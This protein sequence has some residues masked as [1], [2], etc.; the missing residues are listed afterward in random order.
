MQSHRYL[1]EGISGH[2][3]PKVMFCSRFW[4]F[5]SA[6]LKCHKPSLKY[7]CALSIDNRRTVYCQNLDGIR[8]TVG[9]KREQ[10]TCKIIQNKMEYQSVPDDQQWRAAVIRDLLEIKWNTLEINGWMEDDGLDSWLDHLA[11]S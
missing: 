2:L 3:H 10:L 11:V 5:H 6:L 1:I 7:L 8:K 9:Y 4:K